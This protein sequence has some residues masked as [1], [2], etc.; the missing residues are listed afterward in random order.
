VDAAL[1]TQSIKPVETPTQRRRKF[2][3]IQGDLFE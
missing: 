1:A 3:V 2:K